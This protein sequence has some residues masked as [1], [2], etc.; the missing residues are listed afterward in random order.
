MV[1][2]QLAGFHLRPGKVGSVGPLPA[3]GGLALYT[4]PKSSLRLVQALRGLS[5]RSFFGAHAG[6][7]AQL[8]TESEPAVFLPWTA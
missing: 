2:A 3:A 4:G 5:C 1:Q 8:P 6:E 7:R